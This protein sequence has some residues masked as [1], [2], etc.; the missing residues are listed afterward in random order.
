MKYNDMEKANLL[1]ETLKV[2]GISATLTGIA[3]GPVVTRFEVRP[4]IG[5]RVSKF[6]ALADDIALSL[7]AKSVRIEA[8]IPGKGAV[9]IE[10][11]NDEPEKVTLT[12]VLA[13]K[14][15]KEATSNIAFGLGKDNEGNYVVA[16]IAK[17]PHV[18]ISG[19]TGSGKSV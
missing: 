4:A 13:S 16:D 17:M 3:H 8:P 6:A 1:I 18:L 14:A 2:F 10:I 7:A 15:A 19:R 11:P 9:G 5:T 12:D